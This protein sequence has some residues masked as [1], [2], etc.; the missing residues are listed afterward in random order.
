MNVYWY[1]AFLVSLAAFLN[2]LKGLC[3]KLLAIDRKTSIFGALFA[4]AAMEIVLNLCASVIAQLSET[5]QKEKEAIGTS[6]PRDISG[7]SWIWLFV[8][9]VFGSTIACLE[10]F[11]LQSVPL[12]TGSLI[13]A[14]GPIFVGPLSI[15]LFWERMQPYVIICM[16]GCCSG[17]ALIVEPWK[18]SEDSR[19]GNF[20]SYLLCFLCPIMMGLCIIA[21]RQLKPVHHRIVLYHFFG[22]MLTMSL[23]LGLLLGALSIS[24]DSPKAAFALIGYALFDY[25]TEL[26]ATIGFAQ[27]QEGTSQIAALKFL[28]PVFSQLW[29]VAF[30]GETLSALHLTGGAIVLLFAAAVVYIKAESRPITNSNQL[31][32]YGSTDERRTSAVDE[33]SKE[34][35]R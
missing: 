9:S 35:L 21:L 2:S 13:F 25:F 19:K 14:S 1:A 27:A 12:A 29:C 3:T 28:S 15:L 24:V 18:N 33:N 17:L 8:R 5:K 11:C 31:P 4:R 26:C 22:T 6:S 30:L 10:Q 34:V 20:G 16:L 23:V 7:K 32:S